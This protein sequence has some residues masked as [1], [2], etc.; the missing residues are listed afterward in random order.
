MKYILLCL[1]L[2]SLTAL[3]QDEVITREEPVAYG[4]SLLDSELNPPA[5]TDDEFLQSQEE[6]YPGTGDDSHW[7]PGGEE[8]PSESQ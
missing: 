1:L 6:P 5:I 3:A 8:I 4:D 7:S 2:F